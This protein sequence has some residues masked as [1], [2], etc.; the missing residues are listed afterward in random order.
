VTDNTDGFDREHIKA[1][2]AEFWRSKEAEVQAIWRMF[3][4]LP[5]E[6]TEPPSSI[7]EAVRWLILHM[8]RDGVE[9]FR[10]L[11]KRRLSFVNICIGMYI[12][13]QCA[14]WGGNSALREDIRQR[15]PKILHVDDM[16]ICI[17]KSLWETLQR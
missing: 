14:L 7:D 15:F 17:I 13:N 3:S 12:R 9:Q 4:E 10:Q 2:E 5:P 16:S 6:T 11:D 1:I 8:T